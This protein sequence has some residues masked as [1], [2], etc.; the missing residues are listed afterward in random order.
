MR[1]TTGRGQIRVGV[2]G[3]G[4][5]GS[6]LARAVAKDYAQHARVVALSDVDI[7][8]AKALARQLRPTPAIVSFP[9]LLKTCHLIIEAAHA[10][11]A[12]EV[13]RQALKAHRTILV[14]SVGGLL[15]DRRWERLV[16]R[17]RG[18]VYIPSGA[19]AG[20]D[21]V[22]ALA[23]GRLR[24]VALTTSSFL[25]MAS[26]LNSWISL[27]IFCASVCISR[28][29]FSRMCPSSWLVFPNCI[30]ICEVRFSKSL[31]HSRFLVWISA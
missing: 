17:S 10:S 11:G 16:R 23:V 19:L 20:L 4:T 22:K 28:Y 18:K 14:M 31:V 8:H 5:I 6:A 1:M 2:I 13:V 25:A 30:A 27:R 29:R 9:Q 3:C 24:R 12:G 21:G 7:S 15:T 26:K